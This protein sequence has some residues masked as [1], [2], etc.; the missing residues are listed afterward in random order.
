MTSE[1]G[2]PILP[3]NHLLGIESLYPTHSTALPALADTY[4][5]QGRAA[6][7]KMQLLRGGTL[8]NLFFEASAR[9][10]ASFELARK[11]LGADV[12]NMSVKTSAGSKGEAL[13]A[14]ATTL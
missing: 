13:I 11:R 10:Q 5:V 9:P 8:I 6:E 12:M 3:Y 2:A 4:V 7:K 1:T 14:T